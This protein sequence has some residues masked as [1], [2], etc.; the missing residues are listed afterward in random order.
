[1]RAGALPV[2][3]SWSTPIK[4]GRLTLLGDT[5]R[6]KGSFAREVRLSGVVSKTT[7]LGEAATVSYDV[8]R[9]FRSGCAPPPSEPTHPPCP[10]LLSA[11]AQRPPDASRC[12]TNA[13]HHSPRHRPHHQADGVQGDGRVARDGARR[14]DAFCGGRPA[15]VAVRRARADGGF[16]QPTQRL[17]WLGRY[18]CGAAQGPGA[19]AGPLPQGGQEGRLPLELRAPRR[20]RRGGGRAARGGARVPRL[21]RRGARA[22]GHPHACAAA[23]SGSGLRLRLPRAARARLHRRRAR[24][25]RAVDGTRVGHARRRRPAPQ[26]RYRAAVQP[27]R[28]CVP[29]HQRL[30]AALQ[31]SCRVGRALHTVKPYTSLMTE[32]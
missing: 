17:V 8:S 21:P 22:D 6:G 9:R 12:C 10:R 19:E 15:L 13:A 5:G 31:C 24:A 26:A 16:G 27:L 3:A 30:V 20:Q 29:L 4:N 11:A 1:M 2:T 7:V 28:V 25:A 14:L 23:A 18:R 32:A